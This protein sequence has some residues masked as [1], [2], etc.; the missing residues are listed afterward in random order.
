MA[1]SRKPTSS[2]K[3]INASI[4]P[5][6]TLAY[7]YNLLQN[8]PLTHNIKRTAAQLQPLARPIYPA[9]I[10]LAWLAQE[11]QNTQLKNQ[12]ARNPSLCTS[13]T[14]TY[15]FRTTHFH[16]IFYPKKSQLC[17]SSISDLW[18][19]HFT[20]QNLLVIIVSLVKCIFVC[21]Y[22][23]PLPKWL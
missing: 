6:S 15:S 13:L 5:L 11:Y 7:I 3:S 20:H 17:P 23:I 4:N 16:S 19:T 9:F 1:D 8:N 12:Q 18:H 2:T 10:Y 14:A 21:F 22:Q